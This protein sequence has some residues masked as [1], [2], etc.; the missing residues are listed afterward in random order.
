MIG[1]RSIREALFPPPSA[2]KLAW[3]KAQQRVQAAIKRINTRAVG[4]AIPNAKTATTAALRA[5]LGR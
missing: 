1:E 2:E 3:L 4:K 5:E